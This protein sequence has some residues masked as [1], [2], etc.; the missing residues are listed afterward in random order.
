MIRAANMFTSTRRAALIAAA[1]L[2]MQLAVPMNAS[3]AAAAVTLDQ[4]L[5]QVKNTR[6]TEQEQNAARLKDFTANRAQQAAALAEAEKAQ[7]AAEAR[8]KALSTEFDNNE[9]EINEV[10]TLLKQREGNLGELFGVTRQVAGDTANVMEQSIISA[11]Y[12]DRE[13]FLR[14]LA[15][16]KTLPSISELERLWF[17]MQ[18]EMTATG[19]VQKYEHPVVQPDGQTVTAPV[20]RIGPFTIMS[21]GKYLSYLP[22]LKS[23][24]VLTR[25]PPGQFLSAA[26]EAPGS[27]QR[28][29]AVCRRPGS[30]CADRPVR[31]ASRR[32]RAN[33][34]R[35]GSRLR[36]HRGRS[37][38]CR[39]LVVSVHLPDPH[40]HQGRRAAERSR[41]PERRQP[42]RSRHPGVQR[43]CVADRRRLRNRRAADLRSD[44]Q[45]NSADRALPGV[46]APRRRRRSVAGTDRYGH[47]D[48]PDVPE[49]HRV[50]LERPET[51]GPRYQPGDDRDGTRPRYRHSAA[52]RQREAQLDVAAHSRRCSTVKVPACW[53]K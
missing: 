49:H 42:A 53:P 39:V 24:A 50:R 18:R 45:R 37:D 52:V 1:L 26:V 21:N 46:P 15:S 41:T 35:P 8:S 25:Q 29:R 4:L 14:S 33:R 30:R 22:S 3:A 28:L 20:V 48:D 17:E 6:A 34:A 31:R 5:Q 36:D 44:R 2:G 9:K 23:L 27:D 43:R 19:D 40:P 38:R 47:R 11:Q 10:G 16:A 7:Q 12:P 32:G 13:E 51:D